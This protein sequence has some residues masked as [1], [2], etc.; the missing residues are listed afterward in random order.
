MN[1]SRTQQIRALLRE[2][3]DGL[4]TTEL[5]A[6]MGRSGNNIRNALQRMPDVY[7]DRWVFPTGRGRCAAVWCAVVPP[8]NCPKPTRRV[9]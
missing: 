6:R 1:N 8:P 3:P 5:A 9:Q 7:I 4:T 2:N